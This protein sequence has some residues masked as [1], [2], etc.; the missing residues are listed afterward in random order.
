MAFRKI[1]RSPPKG[2][3][4]HGN[5]VNDLIEAANRND[6]AKAEDALAYDPHCINGVEDGTCLT[7]LHIAAFRGNANMV[8]LLLKAPGADVARK[9]RW[10]RDVL[11]A[12]MLSPHPDIKRMVFEF[13]AQQLGLT[14][15]RPSS[16]AAVIALVPR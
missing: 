16:P 14:E 12:A 2:R 9:D 7:A 13:R 1:V 11:D 15:T 3:S 5:F 4:S 10:G 6:I 8:S